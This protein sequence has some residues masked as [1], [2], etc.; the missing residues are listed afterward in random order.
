[1][2]TRFNMQTWNENTFYREQN[3]VAAL[4]CSPCPL[5][6][7]S[8]SMMYVI[9]M[10]NSTNQIEGIGI[11][12][13]MCRLDI[14]YKIYQEYQDFNRH[15]FKGK[16]HMSRQEL[17]QENAAALVDIIEDILFVG[18]AHYKRARG[19]TALGKKFYLK[20]KTMSDKLKDISTDMIERNL[21][22][23]LKEVFRRKY[24]MT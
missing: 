3:G 7:P 11:A 8:N 12:R 6:I 20:L 21:L 9:E 2:T 18:K 23:Y 15:V 24:G 1:M 14:S 17:I 19:I 4:Y 13:N 10:N 22:S 16:Y 5:S